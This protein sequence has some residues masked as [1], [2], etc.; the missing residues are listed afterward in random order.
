MFIGKTN[1]DSMKY[2]KLF[3]VIIFILMLIPILPLQ[4]D[5]KNQQQ[6]YGDWQ[7]RIDVYAGG[8]TYC[9]IG[10]KSNASD[11]IDSYDIPHPPLQPPGRAFVFIKQPSFPLPHNKLW[12][13]WRHYTNDYRVW[14]LTTYYYPM[15]EQGSDILIQWNISQFV[16]SGYRAINLIYN[17]QIINM[18]T[19][20]S[21]SFYSQPY[22]MTYMKI[23]CS[24]AVTH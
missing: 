15:G 23:V 24:K 6:V 4:T 2:Y 20:N 19:T 5:A 8:H 9:I 22:Q 10:E 13:E 14:N 11:G 3:A 1:G 16:S 21:F 12:M 17:G 7:L 18:L